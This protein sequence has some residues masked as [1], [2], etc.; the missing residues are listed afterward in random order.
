MRLRLNPPL[1]HV[2]KNRFPHPKAAVN[3]PHS[4]RF[5]GF[6]YSW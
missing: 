3:A 2:Q 5:A 4:K 6:E 1:R